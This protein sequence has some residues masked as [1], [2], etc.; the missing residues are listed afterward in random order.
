[1]IELMKNIFIGILAGTV[2]VGLLYVIIMN[3]PTPYP[4]DYIDTP[5]S[6]YDNTYPHTRHHA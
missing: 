1:M 6:Y 3:P 4:L 2:I 5:P